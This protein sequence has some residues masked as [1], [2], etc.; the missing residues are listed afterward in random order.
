MLVNLLVDRLCKIS[1][2]D[3]G[4]KSI[5]GRIV[6]AWLGEPRKER[7]DAGMP[8]L[9]HTIVVAVEL[10]TFDKGR[11]YQV[12]IEWVVLEEATNESR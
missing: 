9:V 8:D 11:V 3:G 2:R 6:A 7:L 4:V 10:L 1:L 5:S 12:P